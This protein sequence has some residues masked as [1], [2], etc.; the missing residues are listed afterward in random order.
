MFQLRKYQQE[1]IDATFAW[2]E[3]NNGNPLI[4]LPTGAGKSLV[5]AGI[6][7]QALEGWPKTRILVV[8]HVKE[9]I[10]QNHA[11]MLRMWPECPAGI[12]SA[13]VGRRETEAQ[14]LFCGI[15]SVYGKAAQLGWADLVLIDEAHLVPRDG[16]G[17]YLTLLDDL[18]SMNNSLRVIGLTA[19]PYR[20]DSGRLDTGDNRI[21]HGISYDA[22]L[23]QLIKDGYLSRTVAK[24]TKS[25]I[26]TTGVHRVGGEFVAREL[27]DAAMSGELVSSSVREIL[28]RGQDRKAWLVFCCGIKHAEAVADEL[29]SNGINVATVFGDTDKAQRSL[30]VERF[31]R[32]DLRCI[33]NVNVLTT[34]FDAPHVDLIAVLRPTCSPGLFVQM[35]GRGFRL[36]QGKSDCLLLDF[37]GNFQ[38]HGPLDDIR[39]K[40]SKGTATGEPPVKK[41][42]R[43]ESFVA[44][45]ALECPDCGYVFPPREIT[46]DE[47]PAEVEAIAG[48]AAKKIIETFGVSDVKY[49]WHQG[50][51]G[52]PPSMRVDYFYYVSTGDQNAMNLQPKFSEWVCFQH[53]GWARIKA[54]RWWKNHGGMNPVP[55]TVLSALDRK[56]ELLA[57][58]EVKVK[59]GGEWPEVVAVTCKLEPG[60]S[61]PDAGDAPST[62][63]YSE[64]PF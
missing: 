14:V 13:G 23:V 41:C 57:P 64:I 19:T 43:C 46:H 9:L 17:M 51:N 44:T 10:E 39:H 3:K 30:V 7:K 49:A 28:A 18:G 50:R 22:G 6:I 38:R 36:A 15:Q 25:E 60:Q 55:E 53:D 35:A 48:L 58:C 16:F 12:Y 24:A 21:F 34:G 56:S 42:P 32:G 11:Q 59:L 8:T 26:D 45:A 37:G 62:V 47:R 2:M 31:K 1:S 52:R 27:E 5:L 4:V 54:E 61:E 40:E 33:V 63:D 20:T 29:Q